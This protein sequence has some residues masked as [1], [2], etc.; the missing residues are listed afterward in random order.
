MSLCSF[1]ELT[2]HV[3][4]DSGPRYTNG[5]RDF[6][7]GPRLEEGGRHQVFS[8]LQGRHRKLIASLGEYA[9][10]FSIYISNFRSP[11]GGG[12]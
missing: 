4:S 9:D 12:K 3:C 6:I 5:Q 2:V 10:V 8:S 7:L 1:D 11:P